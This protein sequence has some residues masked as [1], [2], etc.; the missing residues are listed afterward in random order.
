[1]SKEM[2]EGYPSGLAS[3][4]VYATLNSQAASPS[5]SHTSE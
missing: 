5:P 3:A 2:G 1:M 4:F